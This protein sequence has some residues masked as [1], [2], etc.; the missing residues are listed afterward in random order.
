LTDSEINK[1]KKDYLKGFTYK[2]I[3]EKYKITH[4]EL[5]NVIRKNK[6]KRKSN[7]SN[8]AKG[9]QYSKGNKGGTGAPIG[10]K[11][12]L[13]TGE[14]ET[15]FIDVLSEEEQ[16]I[17]NN[18]TT[19]NQKQLLIKEYNLLTIREKRMLSRIKKLQDTQKDLTI[20]TMKKSN[21]QTTG[22]LKRK[23]DSTET[24]T[25][26]TATLEL[27]Q[28]IEEGLTRVQEAK[29]K[30]LETV[31]KI[32]KEDISVNLNVNTNNSILESINKQLGGG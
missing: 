10:S 7:R 8:I 29:R 26:A 31:L 4:N 1:I 21:V 16:Q 15:I 11:N 24:I 30:C 2:Q 22:P 6:W 5:Q 13:K 25:E 3:I 9:N 27:I 32:D 14:Y 19:D 17:Y 12:A 18:E 28:K 23:E 20:I